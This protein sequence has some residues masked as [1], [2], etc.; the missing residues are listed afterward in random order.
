MNQVITITFGDVAE[1]HVGM[2]QI[3]DVSV[4]F[5]YDDLLVAQEW[6]ERKGIATKLIHLD[7]YLE[8]DEK[9]EHGAYFLH[10]KNGLSAMVDP[11]AFLDEQL[12]IDYDKKAFMYG[13]VVNKRARFNVC[14]SKEDQE[15]DYSNR[16][17]RIVSFSKC[18]LLQKVR[19]Y[20][21]EILPEKAKDLMAEGN[22]YYDMSK[23]GIG[24]HGDAERRK[25]I[26]IR[27]GES[28][29]LYFKWY[30]KGKQVGDRIPIQL[31]HGDI[32][33]MSEKTTGF[34]WKK[35]KIYTLRHA[36]GATSFTK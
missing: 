1:N 21:G 18:P 28:L 20:L 9:K 7:D 23:C 2:Q 15:P 13:R 11:S 12:K 26:G 35:K 33:M 25:V 14:F 19:T 5:T 10:I 22:Y 4:G 16:K 34:D 8:I 36:T 31:G 6:F 30:S 27:V 24:Y 29:P 17:G 32:Y 3:G